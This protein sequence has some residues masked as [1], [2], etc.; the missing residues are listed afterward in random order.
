MLEI[1]FCFR[2][3]GSDF[4]YLDADGGAAAFD[5]W[6]AMGVAVVDDGVAAA[7]YDVP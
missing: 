5:E 2:V 4:N 6:A 7:L 3:S 1:G